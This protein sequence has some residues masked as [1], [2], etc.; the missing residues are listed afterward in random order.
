VTTHPSSPAR[1]ANL[2]PVCR[3]PE[4][5][6]HPPPDAR[7]AGARRA[8]GDRRKFGAASRMAGNPLAG[9]GTHHFTQIR[10]RPA[11]CSAAPADPVNPGWPLASDSDSDSTAPIHGRVI[12]CD[13]SLADGTAPALPGGL[14]TCTAPKTTT[15]APGQ[16]RGQHPAARNA[17]AATA[18]FGGR[19]RLAAWVGRPCRSRASGGNQLVLAAL[20]VP[21][22]SRP[23]AAPHS[24]EGT[25]HIDNPTQSC[26][27]IS[28]FIKKKTVKDN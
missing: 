6:T 16:A 21:G 5:H 13:A 28:S 18:A 4:Y 3:A 12:H 17:A 22:P 11:C 10:G 1:P 26:S 27:N 2:L 23:H 25:H 14:F 19:S 7:A 24:S 9:P 8:G 20:P 15:K